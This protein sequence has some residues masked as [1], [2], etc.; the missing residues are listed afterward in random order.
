M[1]VYILFEAGLQG[2]SFSFFRE[3]IFGQLG[4]VTALTLLWNS[5]DILFLL[6]IIAGFFKYLKQDLVSGVVG[7]FR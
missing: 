2:L 7:Y 6:L 3:F 1:F 4:T 5:F